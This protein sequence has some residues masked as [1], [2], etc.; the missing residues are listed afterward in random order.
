MSEALSDLA[1]SFGVVAIVSG[2]P[3]ARLR[4][5]LE[6]PPSVRLVG[7]YG[8]E[9]IVDGEMRVLPAAAGARDSVDRAA[10]ML[11]E[12]LGG[13]GVYVEHKGLSVAVHFRRTSD[14]EGVQSAVEPAI[15]AVAE[16]TGLGAIH[17][18]RLVTEIGPFVPVSKGTAVRDL[19]TGAGLEAAMMAGD[20]LG[21]VPAFRALNG[22][23][24]ALR[25]AIRSAESPEILLDE[26]DRVIDGPLEFLGALRSLARAVTD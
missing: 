7:L 20:D 10:G 13:G 21:D 8:A 1:L 3:A 9:E 24:F 23:S 26:A 14:P 16:E 6:T 12:E 2:R 18:G 19:V 4:A 25:V 22:L 5:L 15:L 17:R 11:Q